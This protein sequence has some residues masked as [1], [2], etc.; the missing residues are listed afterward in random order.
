MSVTKPPFTHLSV[1]QTEKYLNDVE[2][3]RSNNLRQINVI[4]RHVTF[5]IESN[6]RTVFSRIDISI[7]LKIH[8][9]WL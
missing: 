4:D 2:Y 7:I 5:I 3:S 8:H 9:A 1:K 6:S